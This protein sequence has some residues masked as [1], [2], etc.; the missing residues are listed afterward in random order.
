M[1]RPRAPRIGTRSG[2]HPSRRARARRMGQVVKPAVEQTPKE[3]D[4]EKWKEQRQQLVMGMVILGGIYYKWH[5]V[6]GATLAGFGRARRL[7][8]RK[9]VAD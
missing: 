5:Y 8:N 9:S 3:H 2:A 6:G 1:R 4:E 7:A